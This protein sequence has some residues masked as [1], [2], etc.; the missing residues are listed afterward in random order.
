[1]VLILLPIHL[2]TSLA[3]ASEF[4]DVLHQVKG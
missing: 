4:L 2:A 1:V 3:Y